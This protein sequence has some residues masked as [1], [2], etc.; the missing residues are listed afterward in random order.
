M[1]TYEY[2]C[3]SCGYLFEAFQTMSEDPL[4]SCPQCG[5]EVRRLINGG[6]G[7]IFKGSGFYVTDKKG[8]SKPAASPAKPAGEGTSDKSKTVPS[9][10]KAESGKADSV[11]TNAGSQEKKAAG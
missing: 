3:K 8:G 6:S 10:P 4:T 2:E 5:K 11:K 1:P 9:A 7:I